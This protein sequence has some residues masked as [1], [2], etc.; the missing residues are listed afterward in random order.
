MKR[1][2]ER[3][4]SNDLVGKKEKLFYEIGTIQ[5]PKCANAKI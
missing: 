4:S 1:N 3:F 2:F 5:E